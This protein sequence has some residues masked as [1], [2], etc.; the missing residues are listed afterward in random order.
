VS[1]TL[2][3]PQSARLLGDRLRAVGEVSVRNVGTGAV[4]ERMK[5]S[6]SRSWMVGR[7]IERGG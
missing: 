5:V 4:R 6:P 1:V 2:C 7:G 3:T